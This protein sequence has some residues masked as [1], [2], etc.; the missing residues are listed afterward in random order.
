MEIALPLREPAR[1]LPAGVAW[2]TPAHA[3]IMR[4]RGQKRRLSQQLEHMAA[5]ATAVKDA[6]NESVPL[7]HGDVMEFG[8]QEA[9]PLS[10]RHRNTDVHVTSWLLGLQLG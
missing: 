8:D 5:A 3:A 10:W 4:E 2:R 9:A 7:R 6:Y 1:K